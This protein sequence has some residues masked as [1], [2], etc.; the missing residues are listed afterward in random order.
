MKTILITGING[1]LGSHL[2]KRLMTDYNIIGLEY[3]T[4][5]LYRINGL[6]IKVYSSKTSNLEEIFL[7]EN[8]YSV[9]HTATV[10]RRNN[11]SIKDLLET[12]IVLPTVLFSFCE[13]YNTDTFF[14]TDSFFNKLENRGYNYLQ[15][16][17]LS[18]NHAL[19]WLRLQQQNCKLINM[20]IFQMY[21]SGDA[22]SKFVPQI[23]DKLKKNED[24]DLTPGEQTRDFIHVNDVTAA[25][26]VVLS[27]LVDF[28]KSCYIEFDVGSGESIT[29]KE[30]V[31]TAK[32]ILNSSSNLYWGTLSYRENEIMKSEI[33][34]EPLRNLGWK[35]KVSIREGILKTI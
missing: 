4:E 5:N 27:S 14:N 30:F 3:S 8:I 17:T 16:Y 10:Y 19:E 11:E 7:N 23:I 35:P 21:G 20:K 13:K 33:N 15:D 1:F 31:Q 24:I 9:I 28:P 34:I 2:A 25:Y 22:M 26:K 6:N 29:L 32:Q 18:K 12:N